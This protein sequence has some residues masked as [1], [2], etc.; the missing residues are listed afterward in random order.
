DLINLEII[1]NGLEGPSAKTNPVD[2][3]MEVVDS[4]GSHIAY[5]TS[6]AASN[7]D[8]FETNDSS[9]IDL[10]LPTDGTYYVRVAGFGKA[11]G[12]YELFMYRF[13]A[14]DKTSGN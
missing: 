10:T 4:S 1:S 13:S 7:N 3:T 6:S 11:T 8:Q 14:S 5:F 2:S 12:S 9:L